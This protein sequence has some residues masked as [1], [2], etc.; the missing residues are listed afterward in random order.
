[1]DETIL[2]QLEI[3]APDGVSQQID[4]T[5]GSYLIGRTESCDIQ[6]ADPQVQREHARL[7]VS[8]AGLVITDL[9]R[10]RSRTVVNGE[11][12]P[13]QTA[14]SLQPGD[15]LEFGPFTAVVQLPP[16]PEEPAQM[17]TAVAAETGTEPEP[18]TTKASG[19]DGSPPDRLLPDYLRT[20]PPPPD[21]TVTT[22]PGLE[23]HSV[24]YLKYLPAIFHDDFTSR[25]MAIFE[26]I[27]LPVSWNVENFDLF[28]NPDTAPPPFVAWLASWFGF[29]FDH[30]WSD[31]QR[32][33]VLREI[34]KLAA[35]R[36][37]KW[38]LSRLLEIYT[39]RP[40]Q[41]IEE[42]QPPHTFTVRLPFRERDVNRELIE[43]LI[44]SYKP[45]HTNYVLEFDTKLDVDVMWSQLEF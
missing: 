41:I 25:F 20:P 16:P 26:A 35:R 10:R 7:D 5:A 43:Q 12:I 17:E 33:A 30:T 8:E 22:P 36:G 18:E 11:L 40:P 38:G 32:R 13:A 2:F 6:L 27:L 42:N 1:M 31:E 44:E 37:T 19:D 29:R 21:D 24:R 3:T 4:L 34:D 23:R 45:A 28:L 39:G 9:S 14:V 15:Q